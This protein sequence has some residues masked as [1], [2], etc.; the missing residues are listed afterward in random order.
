MPNTWDKGR[1][2]RNS[3]QVREEELG[4]RPVSGWREP[5]TGAAVV[6]EPC[7]RDTVELRATEI[8]VIGRAGRSISRFEGGDEHA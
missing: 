2:S 4:C 8:E 7:A 3:R 6:P 5:A 1:T